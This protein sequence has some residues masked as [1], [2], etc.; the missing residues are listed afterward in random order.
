MT[1]EPKFKLNEIVLHKF[2]RGSTNEKQAFA[3]EVLYIHTETCSAGTQIFYSCRMFF[4][5]R[6]WSAKKEILDIGFTTPE[7]TSCKLREDELK[8]AP[9]SLIDILN[10]T[11][12]V[13]PAES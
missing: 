12:L 7:P 8:S 1:I 11:P 4:A 6:E 5:T 10:N 9:Q 2:M 3:L 13:T